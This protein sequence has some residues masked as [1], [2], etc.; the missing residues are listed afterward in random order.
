MSVMSFRVESTGRD[1]TGKGKC[2]IN[3]AQRNRSAGTVGKGP[4]A[5]GRGRRSVIK[6]YNDRRDV[7]ELVNQDTY[8][9]E[10]EHRVH[11]DDAVEIPKQYR[12]GQQQHVDRV[13]DVVAK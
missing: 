4:A 1:M 7:R 10:G 5:R 6:A 9:I 8:H 11:L 3:A 12:N 2:R 13:A